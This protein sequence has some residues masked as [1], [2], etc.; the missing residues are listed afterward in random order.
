MTVNDTLPVIMILKVVNIILKTG[1]I[2]SKTGY[3][4]LCLNT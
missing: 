2:N 3:F 4:E 1:Y